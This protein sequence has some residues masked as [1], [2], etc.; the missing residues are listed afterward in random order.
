MLSNSIIRP[1]CVR[2]G[3][4]NGDAGILCA[5]ICPSVRG[6]RT[7]SGINEVWQLRSG[8]RAGVQRFYVRVS[9][10][11]PSAHERSGEQWGGEARGLQFFAICKDGSIQGARAPGNR[12]GSSCYQPVSRCFGCLR[13]CIDRKF[14]LSCGQGDRGQTLP[15]RRSAAITP[16]GLHLPRLPV[17]VSTSR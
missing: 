17:P 4:H 6:I 2:V 13:Q 15:R 10:M 8:H 14:P 11:R 5:G 12:T 16:C 9:L 3:G 7:Y 1:F